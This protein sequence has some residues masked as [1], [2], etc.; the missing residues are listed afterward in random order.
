M[1]SSR[2]G[3]SKLS[4]VMAYML[5]VNQFQGIFYFWVLKRD[6]RSRFPE[7]SHEDTEN[8]PHWGHGHIG[9]RANLSAHRGKKQRSQCI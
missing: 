4:G 8:E 5:I 9:Q 6:G 2:E 3:K 7:Q 1:V